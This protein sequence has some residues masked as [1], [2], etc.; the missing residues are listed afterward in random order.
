MT[1]IMF[2]KKFEINQVVANMAGW[3]MGAVPI[4]CR[5]ASKCGELPPPRVQASGFFKKCYLYIHK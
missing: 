5:H 1:G 4:I 3:F 2:T